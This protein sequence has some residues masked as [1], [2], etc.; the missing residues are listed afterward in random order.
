MGSKTVGRKGHEGEKMNNG[1]HSSKDV[2]ACANSSV[3]STGEG[4]TLSNEHK[5]KKTKRHEA[6]GDDVELS[7]TDTGAVGLDGDIDLSNHEIEKNRKKKKKRKSKKINAES[8]VVSQKVRKRDKACDGGWEIGASKENLKEGRT[9]VGEK[10]S[11]QKDGKKYMERNFESGVLKYRKK[12]HKEKKS[13]DK[14]ENGRNHLDENIMDHDESAR[15]ER[16]QK[17]QQLI[18]NLE[19]KS[20]KLMAETPGNFSNAIEENGG[21]IDSGEDENLGAHAFNAEDGRKDEKKRKKRKRD[22]DVSDTGTMINEINQ[23]DVGNIMEKVQHSRKKS[24]K[25]EKHNVDL[26]AALQEKMNGKLGSKSNPMGENEGNEYSI[27]NK[28]G[29]GKIEDHTVKKV[30]KKKKVK[31]VVNGSE[32]KGSDREQRMGK[33]VEG[34]NPLE[35][36]TLKGTSKRVSFSEEVE[37]FPLS[38]D[39][40]SSNTVQKEEMVRGK[41]F[42]HEEDEMVKEAVLNYMDAHGLG[43]EGLQMVLSCKKYPELKNCWKEIGAALPWR[44][45]LSVYNRAHILFER[46]EKGSWTPEEYELVHKFHEKHGSDWKTLA[47]ALGKHRIHV[48][49]TWRRIKVINRRRGKWSQDEYQ[50]LFDLVNMDL[51]MKACE[52]MKSSKHGMLRDNICWTAISEKLGTRATPMCCMK[53]YHQLTSPMVAEGKWLDVDDYHLV[54]ALYNLDACCIEDVDWDNLLDHRSGDLCRKRLNQ[55]VKHI[56]EHGNKSF[57]DQVEILIERYCPDVLEAREAYNSIPVVP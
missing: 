4:L 53:W 36:S 43:E 54:I 24:K 1:M 38:D 31:S 27:E 26:A 9:G 6:N 3:V 10:V 20:L 51:R 49:D 40:P 56:G 15:M 47:E 34:T 48:K 17:K 52:E 42:S 46:D 11:L 57:A 39:G 35:K 25:R 41:R 16:K 12:K 37:V 50:N 44:P 33:G 55:M 2:N 30:K 22:K 18:V 5:K 13:K 32:G 45:Y 28:V 23:K 8:D 19:A 14:N 7:A 29:G 21:N